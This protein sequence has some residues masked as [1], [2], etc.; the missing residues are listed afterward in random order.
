MT[1]MVPGKGI[2]GEVRQGV[3]FKQSL[4]KVDLSTLNADKR[5]GGLKQP[6]T[7]RGLTTTQILEG[8]MEVAVVEENMKKFEKC[9]VGKLW[10]QNDADNIQFKIWME[11]FQMVSAVRLGLDMVLLSSMEDDGVR[12]AV[13]SNKDWW[14][15]CF[16][17]IN[18]STL[19]A[20]PRGR[21]V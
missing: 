12:N 4:A 5:K 16:I 10:D 3:S 11:G 6:G 20:R 21:R 14:S 13:A 19:V 15:R 17:E 7:R 9:W 2:G 18:M 1:N 8:T